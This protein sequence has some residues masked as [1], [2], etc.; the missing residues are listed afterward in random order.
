MASRRFDASS[1]G[2]DDAEVARLRVQ[3]HDVTEEAPRDARRLGVHT[4]G[5][6]DVDRIVAEVGQ[7]EVAQE[8]ATVRV[9]VR[10][11]AAIAARRQLP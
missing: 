5:T 10:A 6:R 11:H 8:Q 7:P 1:F 3:L 4:A 2:R 9:R